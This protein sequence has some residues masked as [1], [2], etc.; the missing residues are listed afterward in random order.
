MIF[1]PTL[2]AAAPEI[3]RA[4]R[5]HA[6]VDVFLEPAGPVYTARLKLSPKPVAELTPKELARQARMI[7]SPQPHDIALVEWLPS[8][9]RFV[10]RGE[11]PCPF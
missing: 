1:A 10:N 3:C 6:E 5:G 7:R 4:I 2:A 11:R 8:M 9:Y